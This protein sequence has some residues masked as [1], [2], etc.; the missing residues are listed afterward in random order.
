[1]RSTPSNRTAAKQ[2]GKSSAESPRYTPSA[3]HPYSRDSFFNR[4]DSDAFSEVP[5]P[6]PDPDPDP[7]PLAPSPADPELN[8]RCLN[9]NE[10]GAGRVRVEKRAVVRFRRAACVPCA[11]IVLWR[12]KDG[13]VEGRRYEDKLGVLRISLGR[14]IHFVR[15]VGRRDMVGLVVVPCS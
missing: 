5:A 8:R 2:N 10:L 12:A 11:K 4:C 15:R 13:R 1:M 6:A 7:D 14:E 9:W 3:A